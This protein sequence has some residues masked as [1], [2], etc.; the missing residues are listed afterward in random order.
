MLENDYDNVVRIWSL[1]TGTLIKTLDEVALPVRTRGGR[2]NAIVALD[3]SPVED[4]LAVTSKDN[5]FKII[6]PQNRVSAEAGR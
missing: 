1:E 3:Y 5:T 2:E 6:D 4:L